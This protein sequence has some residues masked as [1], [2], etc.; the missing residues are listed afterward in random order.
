MAAE[1]RLISTDEPTANLDSKTGEQLINL[2]ESYN[3]SKHITFIIASHDPM[4]INRAKRVIRLKDGRI[5]E[6]RSK[7]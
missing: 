1:P 4:V 3:Q 7:E 6:D 5:V 2:M